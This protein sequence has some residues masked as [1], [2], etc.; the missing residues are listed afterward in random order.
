MTL[1]FFFF[2]C[3]IREPT[4]NKNLEFNEEKSL[5]Y[6]ASSSNIKQLSCNRFNFENLSLAN[7]CAIVFKNLGTC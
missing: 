5:E 1:I 6:Y 7:E 4:R 2:F 3:N